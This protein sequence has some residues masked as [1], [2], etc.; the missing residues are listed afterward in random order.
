MFSFAPS[1]LDNHCVCFP[2]ACALGCILA[3]LRGWT[4]VDDYAIKKHGQ[5]G[6][7]G[8]TGERD[9][10]PQVS[11]TARPGAPK[12]FRGGRLGPPARLNTISYGKEKPFCAQGNEQCW[13][14]NRVDH[15][16]YQ[17]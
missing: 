7:T 9:E 6:R 8:L 2:R 14:R 16:V 3:P 15:F 11:K 13:Q 17:Q 1:E 5:P 10:K 4:V 12:P